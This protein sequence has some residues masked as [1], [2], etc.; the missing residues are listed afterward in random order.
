MLNQKSPPLHYMHKS[1]VIAL[2]S[3]SLTILQ[4]K[5]SLGSPIPDKINPGFYHRQP[6]SLLKIQLSSSQKVPHPKVS[7]ILVVLPLMILID[8]HVRSVE[9]AITKPW[10]AS[11]EWTTP[12]KADTLRVS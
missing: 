10:I 1:R 2:A 12:F 7:P 11:I 4:G 8:P 9:K 3:P 5:G 6:D